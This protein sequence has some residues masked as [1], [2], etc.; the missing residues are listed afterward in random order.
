MLLV[1]MAR[2][3]TRVR[4]MELIGID[5]RRRRGKTKLTPA[6]S[7]PTPDRQTLLLLWMPRKRTWGWRRDTSVRLCRRWAWRRWW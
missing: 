3:V 1:A 7:G 6:L 4:I 5:E 2:V